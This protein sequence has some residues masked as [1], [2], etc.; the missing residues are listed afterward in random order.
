MFTNKFNKGKYGNPGTENDNC[1]V[2]GGILFRLIITK[3]DPI[4]IV[5]KTKSCMIIRKEF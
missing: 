4:K 2:D 1:F 5:A 3:T